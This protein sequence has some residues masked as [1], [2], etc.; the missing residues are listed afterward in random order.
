VDVE[1]T[2]E[3]F[4]LGEQLTIVGRKL[5]LGEAAPAFALERFD[6]SA[7]ATVTLA[8]SAGEVRLLNVVNSLDTPARCG[9]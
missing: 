8:D 5:E 2:G 7:M 3:A 6:G 1:R 9:C 4:E